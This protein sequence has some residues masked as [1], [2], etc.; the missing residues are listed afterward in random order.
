MKS[1]AIYLGER[2]LLP[3]VWQATSAWERLRGLLGRPMLAAGEGFLIPR[4]G[5]VHTVGMA[6]PLDLAFLDSRG[7]I[8]KL[9]SN[10]VPA[11]MAG[12]LAASLTLEMAP[13]TLAQAGIKVGDELSFRE[14]A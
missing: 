6:Y 10:V 11:R 9:A 8:R 4:C 13:G 7:R 12:S 5:M 14:A 3:R 2:C 1:G